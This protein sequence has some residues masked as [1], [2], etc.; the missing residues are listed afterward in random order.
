MNSHRGRW[1]LDLTQKYVNMQDFQ[2]SQNIFT[3]IPM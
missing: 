1:E 3:I 2:T